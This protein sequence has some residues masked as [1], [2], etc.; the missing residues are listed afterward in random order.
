MSKDTP[1]STSDDV[2]KYIMLHKKDFHVLIIGLMT[3]DQEFGS[4]QEKYDVYDK[5]EDFFV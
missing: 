4:V 3:P 5:P 2:R 1:T